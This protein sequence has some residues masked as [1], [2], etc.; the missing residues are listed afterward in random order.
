MDYP[1]NGYY[2]RFP[3]VVYFRP[4]GGDLPYMSFTSAGVHNCGLTA[5]N[6]AGIF[7]ASHIVPCTDVSTRGVTMLSIADQVVR[8]ARSFDE[9]VTRF[10]AFP[11]A[12]GWAYLLVSFGERRM[13]TVEIAH[14]RVAVRESTGD[15]HVQTN[16]FL[17]DEMRGKY[18]T[19]NRSVDEDADARFQ[20][21]EQLLR[22]SLGQLDVH[23]AMAILSDQ[24]D[25]FVQ[26]V[27][28][29]GNTVGVHTTMTS[30]VLS[31]ATGQ[32]YVATGP[33]P[34]AHQEFLA[35]PL[36]SG[37]SEMAPFPDR[38]P[39]VGPS[40]FAQR[41]PAIWNAMQ[42]FI[43]A[44]G[45]YE[46]ENDL[47][48]ASRLLEETVRCDPSNPAYWFQLGVFCLKNQCFEE[49]LG[50]FDQVFSR[51]YLTDQLRRLAHYFRGR[52]RAEL[53]QTPA[54]LDD[55]QAVIADLGTDEK[56]QTAARQAIR[57][58][59]NFGKCPLR[60]RSTM[61]MMQQSDTLHY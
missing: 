60:K 44:K 19:L 32:A 3:T 5:C 43:R 34:A 4:T 33:A 57:R 42:L 41:H 46:Y 28:G 16:R 59:E 8:R 39:L 52:A 26:Q 54:A 25:P 31:P 30:V 29:L 45:A 23:G 6:A 58:L 48:G 51:T 2:D 18:L 22:Q 27:R 15:Y 13:A 53:G 50:A 17:T 1:L 49:A 56:L 24:V 9:A 10:R 21:I 12:C 14:R 61:I 36:L 55:L 40:G 7:V 35:V 47:R 11:A 37:K 20:R 38:L